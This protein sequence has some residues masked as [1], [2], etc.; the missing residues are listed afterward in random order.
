MDCRLLC[1]VY[2]HLECRVRAPSALYSRQRYTARPSL[3]CRSLLVLLQDAAVSRIAGDDD[4]FNAALS[5][6]IK[7]V[8]D[9]VI[10]DPWCVRSQVLHRESSDEYDARPFKGLHV[11]LKTKA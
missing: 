1:P 4:I 6:D 5:G 2:P 7:R 3:L 10:A 8:R 9:H 11:F